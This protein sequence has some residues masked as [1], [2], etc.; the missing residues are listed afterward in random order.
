MIIGSLSSTADSDL[1]ALSS[2]MMADV[3]G[4]NV[5]GKEKAN[6]KTMLL[7]GR[8]TMIVAASAA[9]CFAVDPVQHPRPAR[10]RGRAVGRTRVPGDLELLLEAA[11]RTWPSRSRFS[12]RSWSFLPVR[13]EWIDL[14][15]GVGIVKRH[16]RHDR[17]RRDARAHGLRV[18]RPAAGKIGVVA[19]L[20]SAPFAIGFLHTYPTLSGSLIAYSVSTIVCVAITMMNRTK[21]FD[22]ELIKVRTGSF[23]T[24]ATAGQKEGATR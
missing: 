5:A 11:S 13:F 7:V 6:P 10:V 4:Q 18:L 2:I 23:D 9:L 22:F 16:P 17:Y 12:R 19:T 8:I 14:S 1:A 15:G 20:A 24:E 3:Y 21:S